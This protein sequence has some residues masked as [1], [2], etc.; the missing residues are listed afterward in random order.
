MKKKVLLQVS[1]LI[2]IT[3]SL[4]AL[5]IYVGVQIEETRRV[6]TAAKLDRER[7]DREI[8]GLELEMIRR[9][10]QLADDLTLAASRDCQIL[11]EVDRRLA[12]E[13]ANFEKE[14][15]DLYHRM[16]D[17]LQSSAAAEQL[18]R[19]ALQNSQQALA[20]AN[21]ALYQSQTWNQSLFYPTNHV[22]YPYYGYSYAGQVDP[23]YYQALA[24]NRFM[25]VWAANLSRGV[26][27]GIRPAA[28]RLNSRVNSY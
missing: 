11:A 19:E 16:A 22:A 17:A 27:Q 3:G 8:A 15:R 24:A 13:K 28:L 18:A 20:T 5:A 14:N 25:N 12:I 1:F 6:E 2:L 4:G 7:L 9:D 23:R 26:Y 21:I 10:N